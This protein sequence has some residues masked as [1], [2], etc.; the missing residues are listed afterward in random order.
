MVNVVGI[1]NKGNGEMYW[2]LRMWWQ[3]CGPSVFVPISRL[4]FSAFFKTWLMWIGHRT[5]ERG[6]LWGVLASI[7]T[8]RR[9]SESQLIW[10]FLGARKS[11][12]NACSLCR[13]LDK[14]I[15]IILSFL[16]LFNAVTISF[17]RRVT[18]PPDVISFWALETVVIMESP[19]HLPVFEPYCISGKRF[20]CFC[21][22]AATTFSPSLPAVL[23]SPISL[24][25]FTLLLSLPGLGI[26][27]MTTPWGLVFFF[28]FCVYMPN[29]PKAIRRPGTFDGTFIGSGRPLKNQLIRTV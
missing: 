29:Q 8:R 16:R 6:L 10:N 26:M 2:R 13:L 24:Q 3:P 20:N 4:L 25:Q 18:L 9:S 21:K 1:G 11:V 22:R 19:A 14:S 27:T 5:R 17:P 12:R 23:P 7:L 28:F 15:G